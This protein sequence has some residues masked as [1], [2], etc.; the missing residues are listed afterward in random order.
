MPFRLRQRR[1][2]QDR[3]PRPGSN[4]AGWNGVVMTQV[5]ANA[6]PDQCEIM[7]D[8][9]GSAPSEGDPYLNIV[10]EKQR[11]LS[12]TLTISIDDTDTSMTISSSP[13]LQEGDVV[14]FAG[15]DELLMI[16]AVN[17]ATNFDILRGAYG[18][19]AEGVAGTT[20]G[21]TVDAESVLTLF[22]QTQAQTFQWDQPAD[23]PIIAG[24]VIYI[25]DSTGIYFDGPEI[26]RGQRI[27]VVEN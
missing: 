6:G 27:T 8:R 15:S 7:F 10:I 25:I 17:S 1:P 11:T 9:P 12:F 13:T 4:A 5:A 20:A 21:A 23:S 2:H 24:Q 22:A 3:R 16:S 14:Q 18:T 19:N 26:Q